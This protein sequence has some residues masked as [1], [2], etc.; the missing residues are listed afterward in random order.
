MNTAKLAATLITLSSLQTSAALSADFTGKWKTQTGALYKVTQH[1]QDIISFYE[2]P[3]ADQVKSGVKPHD[4]AFIGTVIT[5][6]ISADFY[7][8]F[9]AD[10]VPAC[11][12]N[13]YDISHIYL[14]QAQDENMMEGDLM[15]Q[16]ISDE[17]VIDKRWLQHLTFKRQ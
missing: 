14:V 11:L 3:N 17:C 2:E 15:R 7:Q 13:T 5:N 8:R 10:A 12:P 6:V 4:L 1:N 16:H 9:S